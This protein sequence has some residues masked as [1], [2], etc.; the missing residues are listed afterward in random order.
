MYSFKT[1]KKTSKS[2]P[3]RK[4]VTDVNGNY[5]Y[6]TRK[7]RF[8]KELKIPKSLKKN[9]KGKKGRARINQSLED[10]LLVFSRQNYLEA[11]TQNIKRRL[12]FNRWKQTSSMLTENLTR[13]TELYLKQKSVFY[14]CLIVRRFKLNHIMKK[15]HYYLKTWKNKTDFEGRKN[16]ERRLK[17]IELSAKNQIFLIN[18]D[19]SFKKQIKTVQQVQAEE[20]ELRAQEKI[21]LLFQK[22]LKD[23][24]NSCLECEY[25]KRQ[26]VFFQNFIEFNLDLLMESSLEHDDSGG[27]E[28]ED[29][30]KDMM[31][32]L[33]QTE[34]IR[35]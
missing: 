17:D 8:S 19:P 9:S 14:A 12:Y 6:G 4:M 20:N 27:E 30:I 2:R 35:F 34:I 7:P 24:F 33:S 31:E 3:K 32:R 11:I 25:H 22:N 5:C 1:P 16:E 26:E 15:A 18:D 23:I 29:S 21:K 13:K 28:E 10:K